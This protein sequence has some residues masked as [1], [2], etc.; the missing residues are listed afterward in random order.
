MIP[1]VMIAEGAATLNG[2][3]A[4]M[5]RCNRLVKR[6]LAESSSDEQTTVSGSPQFG[7]F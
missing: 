1:G 7:S 6:K 5:S 3:N 2:R 4:G